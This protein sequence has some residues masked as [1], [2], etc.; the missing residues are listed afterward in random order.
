[1]IT[2]YKLADAA[3]DILQTKGAQ[4]AME[5]FTTPSEDVSPNQFLATRSPSLEDAS[6]SIGDGSSSLE[7]IA[8]LNKSQF[9]LDANNPHSQVV[10]KPA[11]VG[12]SS[13]PF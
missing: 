1:M 7:D 13:A 5:I 12:Q 11:L 6:S 8:D 9:I 4:E 10:T 3:I 2:Y